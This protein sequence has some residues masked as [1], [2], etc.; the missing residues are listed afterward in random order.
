MQA[1]KRKGPKGKRVS[2]SETEMRHLPA[3]TDLSV[4]GVRVGMRYGR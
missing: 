2:R 4:M 3:A 1:V